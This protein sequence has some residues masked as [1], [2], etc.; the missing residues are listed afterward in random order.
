MQP[1]WKPAPGQVALIE[2][3]ED[4]QRLTGVVM[5]GEQGAVAVNIGAS[6]GPPSPR[7]VLVSF[8]SPDALYRVRATATPRGNQEAIVDL[9]V[10]EVER[11]QR[12]ASERVRT[13]LAAALTAFDDQGGF[14]CVVG[15]TVDVGPGGCRVRARQRFPEGLEPTVSLRL[16]DGGTAVVPGRLLEAEPDGDR[17]SHRVAFAAVAEADRTR[18]AGFSARQAPAS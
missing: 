17:F 13:A 6:A 2:L 9:M 3:G 7:E 15:E 11:V 14:A 1:A 18:L 10:H 5:K 16:P 8:F 4:G 12:R